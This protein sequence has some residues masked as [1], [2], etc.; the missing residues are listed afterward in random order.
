MDSVI[1]FYDEYG[2]FYSSQGPFVL[3]N[4]DAQNRVMNFKR[5]DQVVDNPEYPYS[6]DH[7]AETMEFVSLS[8]GNIQIPTNTPRGSIFEVS[9]SA[10]RTQSYPTEES[11]PAEEGNVEVRLLSDGKLLYSTQAELSEPGTFRA[12]IP[13]DATVDLD[14]GAYEV[15]IV[16]SLPGQEASMVE[17]TSTIVLV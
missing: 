13:A 5:F 8:I 12:T 4:Y 11:S 14:A 3:T 15:K 17:A 9:V 7:W 1:G 6:W 10:E 16:G 2:H